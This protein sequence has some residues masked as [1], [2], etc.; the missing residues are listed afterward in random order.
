MKANRTF[1]IG[2]LDIWNRWD[3]LAGSGSHIVSDINRGINMM[4]V[5]TLH[6]QVS[7]FA[8]SL[9]WLAEIY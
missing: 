1:F 2:S 9:H 5:S 3:I 8:E 7:G 6:S 4:T